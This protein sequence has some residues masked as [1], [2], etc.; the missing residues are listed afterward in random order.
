M[1]K[2][3]VFFEVLDGVI[4]ALH[5]DAID[6]TALPAGHSIM[7]ANVEEPETLLG[8]APEDI[9]TLPA[10]RPIQNVL[11]EQEVLTSRLRA[12]VLDKLVAEMLQEDTSAIQTSI[13]DVKAQYENLS[14]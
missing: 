11:P 4:I 3:D 7:S 10:N 8:L 6:E 13:N 14:P 2:V 5:W 12:L 9:N 1:A